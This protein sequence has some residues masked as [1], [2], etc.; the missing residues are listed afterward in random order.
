ME[1]FEI[2]VRDAKTA[3][4]HPLYRDTVA[5]ALLEGRACEPAGKRGRDELVRFPLPDG[6][7]LVR[8]FR[9]GG[10]IRFL[11]RDRFLRA[12]RPLRELRVLM[13]A[14]AA[15][16][17]V[18]VPLGACWEKRGPFYRGRIA[19]REIEALD[20]LGFLHTGSPA[21]NMVLQRCGL[22]I[23]QMHDAGIW[24]A[25][26]QVA[27]ILV[28]GTKV[29]LVD[30]DKARAPGRVSP[31][32]RWRNLSRLERSM[33]KHGLPGRDFSRIL[34]GYD[35]NSADMPSMVLFGLLNVLRHA[36]SLDGLRDLMSSARAERHGNVP[37]EAV[38]RAIR[39][40]GELLKQSRNW[41]TKRAGDWVVKTVRAQF[42]L[43]FVRPLILTRRLRQGWKAAR[44]LFD[45]GVGVPEPIA[46]AEQR[47]CG[48]PINAA[49][50]SRHIDHAV[51][52]E[53]FARRLALQDAKPDDVHAFLAALAAAI[54]QLAE[55]GAV[56]RD[57]S[58]KNILTTDGRAF[59]FIDLDS[60]VLRPV[61]DEEDR[62]KNHVQI[63]DSFCDLWG[64]EFL[65]PFIEQLLPHGQ[66]LAPW[67]DR[68]RAGQ[69]KRR[70]RQIA[71][72][73]K[74]TRTPN[75]PA[76]KTGK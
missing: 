60:V 14:N 70:S 71:L 21:R 8:S 26:L 73:R 15:G 11:L 34:D 16:L 25:D 3:L 36:L 51:T 49:F 18:P 1:T 55:A 68:V 29:Y 47:V 32:R 74:Q 61:Y 38:W 24:H 23:R 46:Y 56:H 57:L 7:G 37:Q 50:I 2:I 42:G 19:T 76:V 33:F 44:H 39:E 10:L 66:S 20:L 6:H 65:G 62:M 40:P 30:F 63:Y 31:L 54:N 27:N 69:H 53:E 72:W 52:V 35:V 17:P 9:R 41:T 12:N 45:H 28:A 59:Y 75:P 67:L 48:A 13:R 43:G 58:G 4:V 64:D 5:S 22:A